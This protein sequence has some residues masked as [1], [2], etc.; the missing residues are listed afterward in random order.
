MQLEI[1]TYHDILNVIV[2]TVFIY[3]DMAFE[4]NTEELITCTMYV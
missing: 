4:I 3:P 2:V 1:F